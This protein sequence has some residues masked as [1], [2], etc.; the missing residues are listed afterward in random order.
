MVF[1]PFAD[2]FERRHATRLAL[3]GL[4]VLAVS[5]TTVLVLHGQGRI[6]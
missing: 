2:G 1:W 6:G 3:A 5:G 4:L